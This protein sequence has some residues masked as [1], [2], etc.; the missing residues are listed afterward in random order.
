MEEIGPLE[1]RARLEKLAMV[2]S[3]PAE[4]QGLML[5]AAAAIGSV[6]EC[7]KHT[8]FSPIYVIRSDDGLQYCCGH[9]PGGDHQVCESI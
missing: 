5:A 4:I 8:P 1:L 2:D 6:G 9:D 3:L 7:R